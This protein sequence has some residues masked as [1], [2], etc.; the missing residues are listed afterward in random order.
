MIVDYGAGCGDEAAIACSASVH[1]VD[2][3]LVAIVGYFQNEVLDS[4]KV[5]GTI[6]EEYRPIPEFH[7][8]DVDGIGIDECFGLF[9]R[10][11]VLGTFGSN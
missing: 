10:C 1:R 9:K 2:D 3:P 5:G 6:G 11:K 4:G 8:I 7:V